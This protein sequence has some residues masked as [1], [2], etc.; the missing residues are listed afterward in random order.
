MKGANEYRTTLVGSDVDVRRSAEYVDSLRERIAQL[1]DSLTSKI[2]GGS[3]GSKGVL[4]SQILDAAS[5]T[6]GSPELDVKLRRR[7]DRTISRLNALGSDDA[8]EL[9]ATLTELYG[10]RTSSEGSAVRRLKNSITAVINRKFRAIEDEDHGA[11][12][13]PYFHE[14]IVGLPDR[15]LKTVM[16]S[17]S[18]YVSLGKVIMNFIGLPL[19]HTLR[20]D[21]VQVLFY[22]FNSSAG[23]MRNRSIAGFLIR[24]DELRREF[25]SFVMER[26]GAAI[27]VGDFMN[28]ITQTFL[29]NMA[30]VSYGLSTIYKRDKEGRLVPNFRTG[31]KADRDARAAAAA[32]RK[33]LA[34]GVPDGVFKMPQVDL[35]M[36]TLPAKFPP[37]VERDVSGDELTILRIHVFDRAATAYETQ[38]QLLAAARDS[39]LGSVTFDVDVEKDDLGLQRLRAMTYIKTAQALNIIEPVPESDIVDE[40]GDTPIYAHYRLVGG[41]QAVR[42]FVRSTAPTITYGS[43]NTAVQ[44]IGLQSMQNPLLS[45]VNMLRSDRAG[46]ITPEGAGRGGVPLKTIPAELNVTT[47]GCPLLSFTQQFFV[48]VQTG[49]DLDN[50]YAITSLQ[51]NI[52]PGSFKSSFQMTPLQGFGKYESTLNK[53]EAAINELAELTRGS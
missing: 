13:D 5:S 49:T 35:H 42:D 8:S 37:G 41:P 20:F 24:K 36:E 27:S 51:H 47:M 4:G 15:D 7:L 52:E 21:D 30:S 16:K 6:N 28:F 33:L 25:D 26:R 9:A 18:E 34:M 3:R 19:A 53:T 29:D 11:L 48:D 31:R 40:V 17:A 45:T 22:T 2:A 23:A 1:R 38:Q 43:Q 46:S 10:T 12:I 50:I 14:S 32:E 44:S 39:A